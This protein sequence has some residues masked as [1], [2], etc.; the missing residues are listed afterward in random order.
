MTRPFAAPTPFLL[1]DD[2]WPHAPEPVSFQAMFM[3]ELAALRRSFRGG[4]TA[5]GEAI[6][7]ALSEAAYEEAS[8]Q[9][10]AG[11]GR[12]GG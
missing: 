10:E 6:R 11:A 12:R 2:R 7:S 3:A 9:F 4:Q 1:G 8:E 5:H